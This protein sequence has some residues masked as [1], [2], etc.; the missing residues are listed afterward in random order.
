LICGRHRD[1]LPYRVCLGGQKNFQHFMQRMKESNPPPPDTAW[2]KRLVAKAILYRAVEKK[3]RTMKFPAYGAQIT[4]YVVSGLAQKTGGRVDF[5]RLWSRQSVSPELETLVEAWAPQIDS[6]LRQSAGQ[7]NPSEWFKKEE[8]W[9]DIVSRLPALSDPLPPELAYAEAADGDNVAA[10]PVRVHSVADYE[11]IEQCMQVSA[12]TWLQVAELGQK[13]GA[14]HWKVAGICRTLASYAAG[15]WDKK[16]SARQAKP[17]LEALLAC[18]RAG[19]VGNAA[20]A[21]A[22]AIS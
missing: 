16:P 4:A 6:L 13:A 1:G 9:Q 3:I 18:Q 15:G 8:C 11:R 17:A 10:A 20:A 7:R 12:A 2:F 5:D 22:A 14:V 21:E 19:V